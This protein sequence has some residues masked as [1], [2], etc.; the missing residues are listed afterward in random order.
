[1]VGS[2]F[3]ELIAMALRWQYN[4]LHRILSPEV[5]FI[6]G[7]RRCCGVHCSDPEYGK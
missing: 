3:I 5:A 1:M 4:S 6:L 7:E 2:Q